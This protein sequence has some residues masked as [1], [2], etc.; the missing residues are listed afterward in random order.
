MLKVDLQ[1]LKTQSA[2]LE[3]LFDFEILKKL[4]QLNNERFRAKSRH[5]ADKR[6]KLP[7]PLRLL[8]VN[9]SNVTKSRSLQSPKALSHAMVNNW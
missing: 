8:V 2:N 1:P 6:Q 4:Q 5:F 9:I 3:I 7:P